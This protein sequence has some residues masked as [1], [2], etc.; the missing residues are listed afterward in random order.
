MNDPVQFQNFPLPQLDGVLVLNKPSGPTSTRCL[1]AIK[2]LGQKKIGHA[3]TLDPMASG[4]LLVLLGQATKLSSYLLGG[5][6]KVY[7]GTLRIGE[8][9]DTWDALGTLTAQADWSGVSEEDIRQTIASWLG[10]LEQLVPPY[11]AAKH[12]GQPLY[13][14]ARGGKPVPEKIKRVEIS[15]AEILA[16]D[17]PLVR[18]RVKCSSGTYIRS[19]A[20]S[21]GMRLKCG[22]VL[23]ELTREYSHP[24]SIANSVSLEELK[25]LPEKLS[26]HVHSLT[27]ALPGWPHLRL[28]AVEAAGIRNGVPLP[29]PSDRLDPITA[30]GG[31][32]LLQDETGLD[33][34]LAKLQ[35]HASGDMLC[36]ARGLWN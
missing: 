31:L 35:R 9:T 25:A 16:I 23:T 13:K 21:L 15:Q 10:S 28:S 34:A 22:A 24:F 3:G 30:N 12:L 1:S 2:R 8:E 4:V 6:A 5:G 18:F 33:L 14:L 11:S 26:E 19:L 27:E 36:V 32:V 17:L 29:C 7:T 20:H